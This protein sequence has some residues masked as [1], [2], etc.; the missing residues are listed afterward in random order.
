MR[1][2]VC[3]TIEADDDYRM[4]IRH[5]WGEHGTL[6][7]RVEVRNYAERV[8][9]ATND[10]LMERMAR[11]RRRMPPG[12][13]DAVKREGE[14]PPAIVCLGSGSYVTF[15]WSWYPCPECS[16]PVWRDP[17]T[18]GLVIHAPGSRGE[19]PIEKDAWPQD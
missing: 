17:E 5:Q 19:E 6:A 9:T 8:G 10:D 15:G 4:A 14:S 7:T 1:V 13:T 12:V 16:A 18:L 3:Y 11:L 2:R